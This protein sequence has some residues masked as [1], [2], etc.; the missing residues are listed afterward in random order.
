M[1]LLFESALR[2]FLLGLLVWALLKLLRMR[3]V[4]T[5]TIIWTFVLFVA[6]SMPLLSLYLPRF[7]VTLRHM[8][9]AAPAAG[10]P[11][12]GA[13]QAVMGLVWFARHGQLVLLPVYLLGLLACLARLLTGLVLTLQLYA[14]ARPVQADW[15][16]VRRIRASA[17]L[18]SPASLAHTILLPADFGAWGAP[19]RDAVLAHEAAHI[20]RRDFFV[21]LAASLHCALFWFSPFAWWL[22]AKLAEIAESAS[23]DAAVQRLNDPLMYAEILVEVARGA[24]GA[25]VI[26]AMA[27]GP[28]IQQRIERILC[29]TSNRKLSAPGRALLV[30]ALTLVTIAVATAEAAIIED[31]ASVA[32]LQPV[33]VTAHKGTANMGTA[34]RSAAPRGRGQL[35]PITP[36]Q[37]SRLADTLEKPDT[38]SYDPRALLAPVYVAPRAYL[39][40]STIVHAGRTFYVK[41]TERPVAEVAVTD[42]ALTHGK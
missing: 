26:V 32:P 13:E 35:S 36:A 30:V 41:S 28:L 12:A 18:K 37:V 23:D 4:G 8:A 29:A 17:T 3:D 40:A 5:E 34:H 22:R 15:V 6:L 24:H 38:V 11:G 21:Q 1:T 19:K 10:R 9:P 39:P 16:G 2:S 42:G 33:R 31:P 7:P 27:K 25:P 20:A 14:R